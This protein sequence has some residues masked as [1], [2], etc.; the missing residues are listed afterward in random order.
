MIARMVQDCL[1]EDFDHAAHHRDK[2]QEEL[3]DIQQLIKQI[4]E[5]QIASNSRG[6]EPSTPQTEERVEVE[7]RD[8]VHSLPHANTTFYITPSMLRM[9]EIMGQTP[10]KDLS[11]IQLVLTRMPSRALHKLQVSV[12]HEVQSRAH[13]DLVELQ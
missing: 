12:D 8:P 7:E 11:H 4:G 9:D 1:A 3:A 6:I 13:K 5:G 10:L 2:I